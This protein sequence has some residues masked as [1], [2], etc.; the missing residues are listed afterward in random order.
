MNEW[1]YFFGNNEIAELLR[2]IF[3]AEEQLTKFDF[4]KFF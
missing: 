4:G 2:E 3:F 1:S